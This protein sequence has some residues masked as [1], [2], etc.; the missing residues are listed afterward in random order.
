MKKSLNEINN[1]LFR[2]MRDCK[3]D[4]P[5]YLEIRDE[6]FALNQR[7]LTIATRSYN[8]GNSYDFEDYRAEA[9][10]GLLKAIET[11]N[12]DKGNTFYTYAIV[13]MKSFVNMYIRKY[14]RY[15]DMTIS[16]ETVISFSSDNDL[17]LE[18]ILGTVEPEEEMINEI[19][20]KEIKVFLPLLS[21]KLR[22]VLELRYFDERCMTQL[23]IAKEI[24][25]SRSYVSRLE[26]QAIDS[27]KELMNM[28]QT[29]E[30][31]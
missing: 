3:K 14:K 18:D 29:E 16:V 12:P 7:L 27:L 24:G 1:E 30:E 22:K 31:S 10:K 9:A 19:M 20:I 26:S 25:V 15:N 23:E 13:C 4:S 17:T 28:S 5:Q 8:N 11:F 2:K 6:L 21:E